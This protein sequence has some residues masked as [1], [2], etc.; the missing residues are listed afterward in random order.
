MV[1]TMVIMVF[2]SFSSKVGSCGNDYKGKASIGALSAEYYICRHLGG[3]I[4]DP[5]PTSLSSSYDCILDVCQIFNNP[6]PVSYAAT[7]RERPKI[8]TYF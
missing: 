3:T 7:V 2:P 1:I 6:S 4:Y 8:C 5:D